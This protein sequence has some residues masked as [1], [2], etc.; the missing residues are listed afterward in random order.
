MPYLKLETGH[1]LF[2]TRHIFT[3]VERGKLKVAV[4]K[5][6]IDIDSFLL[7]QTG[8]ELEWVWEC[9]ATEGVERYEDLQAVREAIES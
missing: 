5:D 6:Y 1:Y 8:V 4:G 9:M 3:K 7:D 2:G